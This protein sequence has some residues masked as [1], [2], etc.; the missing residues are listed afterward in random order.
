MATYQMGPL[1][2]EN[3]S[4]ES[5]SERACLVFDEIVYFFYLDSTKLDMY[6]PFLIAL[7]GARYFKE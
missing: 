5:E 6:D 7:S 3:D 4:D 2:Q 1:R